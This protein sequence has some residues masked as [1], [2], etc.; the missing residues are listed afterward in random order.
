VNAWIE[1]W[2][3]SVAGRWLAGLESRDRLIVLSLAGLFAVAVLTLG[4][5]GPIHEWSSKQSARY[6]RQL[7]L[8]DW[9][10]LNEAP[11]RAAGRKAPG[12]AAAT[13]GGSLLTLVANTAA[14]QGIQLTRYQ[15]EAGG[16]VS[17]VLQRQEFNAIVRWLTAMQREQQV[18]V[19]QLSIDAHG[20]PGLV[21]ARINL[22]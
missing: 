22:I 21:N 4:V 18:R 2:H 5:I 1:R 16:G 10:R 6:E 11:A 19:R 3:A 12:G 9:M 20:E 17:V 8:L 7:A 14:A 15:P 13:A